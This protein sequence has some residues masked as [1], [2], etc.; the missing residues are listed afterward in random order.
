LQALT[1]RLTFRIITLLVLGAVILVFL[2]PLLNLEPTALRAWQAARLLLVTLT[3]AALL[4]S[5]LSVCTWLPVFGFAEI[6]PP[7]ASLQDLTCV[8]LC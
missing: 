8:R 7:S 4:V 1:I 2:A 5:G 6:Q 3:A